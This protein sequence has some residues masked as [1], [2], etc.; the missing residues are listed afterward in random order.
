ADSQVE[1]RDAINS[2]VRSNVTLNPVDSRGL[3]AVVPGG[4]GRQGSR[5]GLGAFSGR[6]VADQFT[7]LAS[8]QETLQTLA[9]ETGGTAFIDTND[10]GEAFD[11]VQRGFLSY[12]ILG[13]VSSNGVHDGRYRRIQV[14]LKRTLD[15]TVR[16][17]NGYYADR[18]FT[19]T[20]KADRETLL[21]DQLATAIPATDVPLF[22]TAGYFR[23]PS[24][25]PCPG[26]GRSARDSSCYFVPLSLAV[27]GEAVPT[28]ASAV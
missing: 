13:Y 19:H 6:N 4:G 11:K 20:A 23:L 24:S 16:A 5:G 15:A 17:R 12:Y 28:S 21:Q 8:Q 3:L 2:C 26:A 14:R 22:V 27:P 9:A 7:Q 10:F 18:D 25:Q 1:M